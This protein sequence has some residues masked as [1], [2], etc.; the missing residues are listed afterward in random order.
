MI[1]NKDTDE[2]VIRVE[3]VV[4]N[5]IL[6]DTNAKRRGVYATFAVINGVDN[7]EY[8]VCEQLGKFIVVL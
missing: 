6:M 1:Q 8:P 3:F 2:H 5:E 7:V 4:P